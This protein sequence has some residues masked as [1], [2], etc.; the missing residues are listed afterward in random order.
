VA[1]LDAET[2]LNPNEVSVGTNNG[3]GIYL[4]PPGTDLPATTS[5]AFSSEDW[6]C[7]GYLSED[8][9]TIGSSTD[10]EQLTPWQSVAPIKTIITSRAVTMQFVMWQLNSETLG[11]YFDADPP[12]PATDGSLDFH[13][14]TDQAG[15]EYAVAV[16]AADGNRVLRIGFGRASLSDAGDMQI[17]RGAV[18][19]L[20]VTLSALEDAGELA[21]IMLGPRVAGQPFQAS[22]NGTGAAHAAEARTGA[23]QQRGQRAHHVTPPSADPS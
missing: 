14:R 11:L 23:A 10:S 17:Q 19:P 20:D 7:L 4:G 2:C 6:S 8:G 3:P 1:D 16:D 21:H 13:V 15:H 18:I 22:A 9:P 5:A 12:T